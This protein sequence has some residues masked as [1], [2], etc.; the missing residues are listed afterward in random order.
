[1]LALPS[2]MAPCLLRKQVNNERLKKTIMEKQFEYSEETIQ[3]FQDLVGRKEIKINGIK[4][5]DGKALGALS[6]KLKLVHEKK[7]GEML[8]TDLINL[9]NIFLGGQVIHKIHLL[10]LRKLL[11]IFGS[12]SHNNVLGRLFSSA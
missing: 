11:Q 8:R 5:L 10:Q 4:D 1:M 2:I 3:I 6:E 9:T 7:S 12:F